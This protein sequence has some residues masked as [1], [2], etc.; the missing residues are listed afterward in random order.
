MICQ[1]TAHLSSGKHLHVECSILPK[2][3]Y[4]KQHR[5][6]LHGEMKMK[7]KGSGNRAWQPQTGKEIIKR[8]AERERMPL[9]GCK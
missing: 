3:Y 7:I 8:E 5:K 2:V 6:L 4:E 1:K 9:F